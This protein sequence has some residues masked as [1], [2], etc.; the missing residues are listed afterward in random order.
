M[1]VCVLFFAY[2][3]QAGCAAL[4]EQMQER[5]ARSIAP[6]SATPSSHLSISLKRRAPQTRTTPTPQKDCT[7][8]TAP[9]ILVCEFLAII[10]ATATR[11]ANWWVVPF[12]QAQV[13][14]TRTTPVVRQR[15]TQLEQVLRQ[16]RGT[17]EK[18]KQKTS[19]KTKQ[20]WIQHCCD[21]ATNPTNTQQT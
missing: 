20:R 17:K 10:N 15:E 2:G 11:C 12:E 5:K 21:C 14:V 18:P 7:L 3:L 13:D 6:N 19:A 16:L 9:L 8:R 4:A 1:R